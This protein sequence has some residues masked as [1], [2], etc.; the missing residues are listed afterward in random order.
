[1]SK[2]TWGYRPGQAQIFD[3]ADGE[4]L[5]DGWSDTMPKGDHPNELPPK[6]APAA[7]PHGG[8]AE[9]W[10]EIGRLKETI[11]V[12]GDLIAAQAKAIEE[13]GGAIAEHAAT[14]D[15]HTKILEQLVAVVTGGQDGD[16]DK[17]VADSAA[18]AT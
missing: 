7:G 3:L 2:L 12:Q 8:L 17:T 16:A 4:K 10:A 13:H 11:G 14:A 15:E 1:M 9:L 6:P 18:Q 5:P